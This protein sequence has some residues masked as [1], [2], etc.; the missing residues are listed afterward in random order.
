MQLVA[1]K[2]EVWQD[3]WGSVSG[4]DT[5]FMKV[6]SCPVVDHTI[7]GVHFAAVF[8]QDMYHSG[9]N[10]DFA[11]GVIHCNW[12]ASIQGCKRFA[13][14]V[15]LWLG[16]I[17]VGINLFTNLEGCWVSVVNSCGNGGPN[18][19]LVQELSRWWEL[20]VNGCSLE[21]QRVSCRSVPM[22]LAHWSAC[23]TDLTHAFANSFNCG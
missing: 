20:G 11:K 12:L 2:C 9:R 13:S 10:P 7:T 8:W 14:F 18:L 3:I 17:R 5:T 22:Y 16:G 21:C 19:V 15:C 4:L 1:Q 6:S 23:F